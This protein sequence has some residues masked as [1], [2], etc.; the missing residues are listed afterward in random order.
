[1]RARLLASVIQ[2]FL[3]LEEI[4]APGGKHLVGD[5][6]VIE[7]VEGGIA[8]LRAGERAVAAIDFPLG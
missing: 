7:G 6:G 2:P 4:V 1:M 3:E 5:L 8:G